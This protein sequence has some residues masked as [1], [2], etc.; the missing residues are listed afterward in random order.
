[1]TLV[2]ND[3]WFHA[4]I[5]SLGCMGVI[6]SVTIALSPAYDL[7][8]HR[9]LAPWSRVRAELASRAPL[10]AFRN[11]EVL[12]NPYRRRD[13][14]HTCLVTERK[15]A[16]PGA[17]R[18]PLSEGRLAAE[19]LTFASTTQRGL[20]ELMNSQPR[21]VPTILE[22]GLGQLVTGKHG[23]VEQS[24]RIYNIGQINAADVLSAEYFVPLRDDLFLDAVDRLIAI[25]AGNR[26][27][28]VV[29]TS[30]ISLRFVKGSAAHLSMVH[31][32]GPF[33]AIEIPVFAGG[34]GAFEALLSYEQALYEYQARPHW[35]Q[36]NE[37]TGTP[38]GW[39]RAYPAS[40]RWHE[41]YRTLNCRGVFDNHFTDRLGLSQAGAA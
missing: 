14:E 15:L 4:V 37:L 6:H 19:A 5:V 18:V 30:P 28:G 31:G 26:R 16:R 9:R 38:G 39:Q 24:Y 29:Q 8:E 11:Y 33:C 13:G 17:E 12:L 25:V 3:D 22:A 20:L 34:V 21:L 40:D 7:E 36:L 27:H 35:G 10:H 23:H 32:P 41:V 1:M 2:Q